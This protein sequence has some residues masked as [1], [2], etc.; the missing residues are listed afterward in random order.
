MGNQEK[1]PQHA[2]ES[3]DT[4]NQSVLGEEDPGAA[5][6]T[7]SWAQGNKASG[8]S[9]DRSMLLRKAL[10]RWENEGGSD[11]GPA[12]PSANTGEVQTT[13]ELTNAELVQLQIRVIALENLV[14]AL[15]AGATDQTPDAARAMADYIS[16]RSGFT[17]H[18]LTLHAAA[19]MVH[20]VERS[21]L[22][23]GKPKS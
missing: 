2:P 7:M 4:A 10:S 17:P 3:D 12:A 8:D 5:L 23:R 1:T 16:P 18:R 21:T 22:F 9:A 14:I 6:D 15:L 19:Q 13:V 20:L 11:G